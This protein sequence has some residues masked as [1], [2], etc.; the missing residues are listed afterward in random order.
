M[1]LGPPHN[2]RKIQHFFDGTAFPDESNRSFPNTIPGT[3]KFS[4]PVPPTFKK[5]RRLTLEVSITKGPTF[6]FKRFHRNVPQP[7]EGK[8]ERSK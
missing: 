4:K 1:W 7:S 2:R 3:E 5:S 8:K 6:Q